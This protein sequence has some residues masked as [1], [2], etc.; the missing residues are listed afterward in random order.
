[1]HSSKLCPRFEGAFLTLGKKWNGLII[2]ILLGGPKRFSD[3]RTVIPEL[4]D[5][6]LSERLK[7]LE[8][9]GIVLRKVYPETPVRIEY[10]LTPMGIELTPVMAEVQ[11]WAEKWL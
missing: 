3:I 11:K 7:E 9:S 5:R 4:S 6:I 8:S 10:E 1:M 2:K